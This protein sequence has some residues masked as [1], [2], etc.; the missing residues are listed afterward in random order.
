MP[1]R[2][3]LEEGPRCKTH[4]RQVVKERKAANH[5]KRVQK[6]YGLKE[7]EYAALYVFQGGRCALCRRATG[8]S[9][10]LAVDHDHTTGA[11]RGLCCSI[12]NKWILG[13]ARDRIDFFER[14]IGYLK[15]SPYAAMK[16]GWVDWYKDE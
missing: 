11:V 14:C 16:Q 1:K 2:P 8:L 12:C 5:E 13:H 3:A 6:V 10:N 7:G 15:F 9:K 4:W